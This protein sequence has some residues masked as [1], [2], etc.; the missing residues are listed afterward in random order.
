MKREVVLFRLLKDALG[1]RPDIA[2]IR[3]WQFDAAPYYIELEYQH[4][5][6][7]VQWAEAQGGIAKV[8]LVARLEIVRRVADAL[9]AAH[10]VGILHKD[11]KPSNVLMD[12]DSQGIARPLLGDFGIGILTDKS[13]LAA[14]NI[15][16]MTVFDQSM[17][18]GNE[19]SRTGTRMY[20]PP[21]SLMNKPYTMQGDIYSLGVMLYQ[22]AAGDLVR[23]LATGWERDVPDELLREDIAA[24]VEGDPTRRLASAAELATRLGTLEQRRAARAEAA[25]IAAE[26]I[27]A[28]ERAEEF[29]LIATRRKKLL[30][31]ASAL[32]VLLA[33][34]VSVILVLASQLR[35]QKRKA[36]ADEQIAVE[37]KRVAVEA[38]QKAVAAEREAQDATNA[39]ASV[40]TPA[41]SDKNLTV[42]DAVVNAEKILDE[43]FP[44]VEVRDRVRIALG[45][46]LLELGEA[47][48]AL[49]VLERVSAKRLAGIDD[50]DL[51][52]ADL[53]EELAIAEINTDK[54]HNRQEIF[55]LLTKAEQI[56]KQ[57][58]PANA[59]E[60]GRVESEK[61]GFEAFQG[62][63]VKGTADF[64]ISALPYFHA[65]SIDDLSSYMFA[66]VRQAREMMKRGEMDRAVDL[67]RAV[68]KPLLDD[69]RIRRQVPDSVGEMGQYV[70]ARG[71]ID[72]AEA[73]GRISVALSADVNGENDPLHGKDMFELGMGLIE[74]RRNPDG[75]KFMRDG[76]NIVRQ[77]IGQSED[78]PL[79]YGAG[80]V[81]GLRAMGKT[82]EAK[83]LRDQLLAL[84]E[85][86]TPQS[87]QR[88]ARTLFFLVQNQLRIPP[89]DAAT[90]QQA[91][92]DSR[93]AVALAD[94]SYDKHDGY[95]FYIGLEQ[96]VVLHLAQKY[97]DAMA[98]AYQLLQTIIPIYGQADRHV[99]IVQTRIGMNQLALGQASAAAATLEKAFTL[100]DSPDGDAD[101]AVEALRDLATAQDATGNR[102][103]TENAYR[104]YLKRC[105]TAY[106]EGSEN[107]HTL[108][109]MRLLA[110]NLAKHSETKAEALTLFN[111][112]IRQSITLLGDQADMTRTLVQSAH[113]CGF[114]PTTNTSALTARNSK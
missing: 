110:V 80:L 74:H 102:A 89:L 109:A 98:A 20:A 16:P 13:R 35:E 107:P 65:N 40:I 46:T 7:L 77:K 106:G 27:A 83:S 112:A 9:A 78:M 51:T 58:Q 55:G 3:D 14:H 73:L 18:E 103:A 10:S 53:F 5:G 1:S 94:Q 34:V 33:V 26:A 47:D 69:P 92:D 4:D 64:L 114:T 67:F 50:P 15:T 11:I 100:L 71:D 2:A 113:D 42:I 43:K 17:I 91:E 6:N 8:P 19:S 61:A 93:D 38:K 88:R 30:T 45:D 104:Q 72:G 44:S 28:K 31:I 87:M 85:D 49:A 70:L 23:P 12:R 79:Q 86:N 81:A 96:E 22:M 108:E 76:Y 66:E 29:Q 111:Q 56:R 68:C 101:A 36:V 90:L 57:L 41:R 52:T 59:P 39:F 54:F 21:E 105:L 62:S 84:S 82:D 25:R 75:L 37:Q 95:Y 63:M 24:A 97:S 60:I 32:I 48:Q 99:G